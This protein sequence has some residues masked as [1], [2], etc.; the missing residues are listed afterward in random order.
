MQSVHGAA[1]GWRA[2]DEMSVSVGAETKKWPVAPLKS[3]PNLV[4]WFSIRL[5]PDTIG[6]TS[7]GTCAAPP[8]CRF[9]MWTTRTGELMD[10]AV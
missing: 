4:L 5:L 2:G 7:N 1:A 9:P 3:S 6:Q 10:R 8:T